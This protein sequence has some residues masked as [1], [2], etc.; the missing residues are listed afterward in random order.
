MFLFIV[1]LVEFA[2]WMR[3]FWPWDSDPVQ[4]GVTVPIA[5]ALTAFSFKEL[6]ILLATSWFRIARAARRTRRRPI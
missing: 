4:I 6:G 2:L 1:F 5:L 3:A